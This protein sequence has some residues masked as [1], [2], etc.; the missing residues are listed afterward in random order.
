VS[1]YY[2]KMKRM[3]DSLTDLDY[4]VFDR[5]FILNILWG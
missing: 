5:N 3:V 4:A 1:D 2:R